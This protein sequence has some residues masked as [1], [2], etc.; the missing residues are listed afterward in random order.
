MTNEYDALPNK[1]GIINLVQPSSRKIPCQIQSQTAKTRQICPKSETRWSVRIRQNLSALSYKKKDGKRKKKK[2]KKRKR[3]K[4]ER[5]HATA[6]AVSSG[7]W[8][9]RECFSKAEQKKKE[10][11]EFQQSAWDL[12]LVFISKWFINW[13]ESFPRV[14]KTK[15]EIQEKI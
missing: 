13:H 15:T 8:W 14:R 10:K 7:R 3:K 1:A 11:K 2:K 6:S 4:K 5:K 12:A 9:V